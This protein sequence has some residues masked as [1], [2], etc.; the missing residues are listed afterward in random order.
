MHARIATYRLTNGDAAYVVREARQGMLP[1][2]QQ[3]P[4][5]MRYGIVDA[6]DGTIVSL[7][8]W[9]SRADADRAVTAAAG[10]V[11]ER[12]ADRITLATASVGDLILYEGARS[13]L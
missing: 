3:A 8:L 9:E 6:G 13:S 7:S 12:L 4:G 1:I 5:F 2:F 10:F 11:R